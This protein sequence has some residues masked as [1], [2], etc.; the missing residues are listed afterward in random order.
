M[1]LWKDKQLFIQNISKIDVMLSEMKLYKLQI[2]SS[3]W[4]IPKHSWWV[5]NYLVILW[6]INNYTQTLS[7]SP[8]YVVGMFSQWRNYCTLGHTVHMTATISIMFSNWVYSSFFFWKICCHIR[9]WSRCCCS[10]LHFIHRTSFS[11]K[12]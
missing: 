4:D 11:R 10:V 5:L 7:Y 8:V 1:I 6:N 2:L 12:V 3:V 9:I